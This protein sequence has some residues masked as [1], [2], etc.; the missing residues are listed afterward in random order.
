MELSKFTEILKAASTLEE[1]KQEFKHKD[2]VIYGQWKKNK[3]FD[4]NHIFTLECGAYQYKAT[5]LCIAVD[6]DCTEMVANLIDNRADVNIADDNKNTP[7]NFA[8]ENG[9][10]DTV[11]RL[12]KEGAEVNTVDRCGYTPLL[13]AIARKRLDIIALLLSTKGVE[14][15]KKYKHGWTPLYTA[16]VDM[17]TEVIKLLLDTEGVDINE[18]CNGLTILHRAIN[19]SSTNSSKEVVELLLEK[20]ENVNAVGNHKK[21]PLHLAAEAGNADIVKLLLPKQLDVNVVDENGLTPLHCAAKSGN[22][23]VIKLLLEKGA[24]L[25]VA[26]DYK[27]TPL[28][29]AVKNG[30]AKAVEL[31]LDK[32]DV[33]AV[34]CYKRTPLHWAVKNGHAKVVELLLDKSDVN[35]VDCYKR[36]PLHYAVKDGN[37]GVVDALIKAGAEL[38]LKDKYNCTPKDLVN[39]WI[40]GAESKEKIL[41]LLEEAEEKQY[42]KGHR[43]I[44]L[45]STQNDSDSGYEEL[46]DSDEE[47]N[48]PSFFSKNKWKIRVGVDI[49]LGIGVGST[50]ALIVCA[51]LCLITSLP[52]LT[53]LGIAALSWFIS[54][55]ISF[56]I[57][58]TESKPSTEIEEQNVGKFAAAVPCP[59]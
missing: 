36:T 55:G 25:N 27:R 12:L 11:K 33:N 13:C 42:K 9:N 49:A 15:N 7:L 21:T 54:G 22:E 23:R 16:V 53:I 56:G 38:F 28:H 47:H 19:N 1:F 8:I 41:R 32:S 44:S 46:M 58:Y 40:S 31:L 39:E 48:E 6:N 2:P 5:L 37:V 29:W 34:D 26:D 51:T 59:G 35:A 3:F 43:E 4:V 52:V 18:E 10:V 20:G 45:P 57:T 24:D 14:V 17:D 50:V 30:H